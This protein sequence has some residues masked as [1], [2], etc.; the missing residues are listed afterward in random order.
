[1][2]IS[3]GIPPAERL[4]ANLAEVRERI[5]EAAIAS[6]RRAEAVRLIAVTKYVGPELAAALVAAGCHDLGE[7][8]PQDLW[9]KAAALPGSPIRWHLIGH[10]Q[11]NKIRRTLPLV[12]LIHSVDSLRLLA[13]IDEEH[14]AGSQ[15]TR[16]LL[17]V[18]ISGEAAKHGLKPEELPDALEAASRLEHVHVEGL[19]GMAGLEGGLAAAERD[20]SLLRSLRDRSAGNCPS[21]VRLDELSMGMSGDYEIAI[22]HGA[23]MVRVGSALFEGLA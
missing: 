19:M 5:A 9:T 18:N 8:R 17:E 1:M 14:A 20:F 23:T 11:R 21:N 16:I 22:R 6:G 4:A 3:G 15:P 13:A 7:A 12:E 10:L 2:N